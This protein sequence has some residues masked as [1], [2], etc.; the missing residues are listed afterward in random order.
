MKILLFVLTVFSA[1]Y[2]WSYTCKETDK[3]EDLRASL[4]P[5]RDQDSIGWC[6]TFTAAD[7]VTDY[8]RRN[9]DQIPKN[10][11]SKLDFTKTENTVS[12]LSGAFAMEAG[13]SG[14]I[15]FTAGADESLKNYDEVLEINNQIV[16]INEELKEQCGG[17]IC[18]WGCFR[19]SE[20]VECKEWL[21]K[22][23]TEKIKELD[24]KRERLNERKSMYSWAYQKGI[25]EGGRTEKI[26]EYFLSK[27]FSL[28][29]QIS[30]EDTKNVDFLSELNKKML[31]AYM[32]AQTKDEALCNGFKVIKQVC[33]SCEDLFTEIKPT[34]ES[35]FDWNKSV[36]HEFSNLDVIKNKLKN[37]DQPKVNL[38]EKKNN[39]EIREK[40]NHY[41]GK[42]QIVAI[43]YDVKDIVS[44]NSGGHASSLVGR[45]CVRGQEHFIL[46]NS[47]GNQACDDFKK[48]TTL[49]GINKLGRRIKYGDKTI[50]KADKDNFEKTSI[51]R[52]CFDQCQQIKE[53][54]VRYGNVSMYS[55]GDPI[56]LEEI[57]RTKLEKTECENSCYQK[58]KDQLSEVIETF[59][60]DKGYYFIRSEKLLNGLKD[61]TVIE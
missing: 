22:H 41:L 21:K 52:K 40:I 14:G 35:G 46:R 29:K 45:T 15:A 13:R 56:N 16:K 37:P 36:F 24:N 50:I 6:Y 8:L 26:A 55:M 9:R 31:V 57:T 19:D 10:F 43:G 7:L 39:D 1:S 3:L 34:L 33:S 25:I 58:S 59:E 2:A 12:P 61:I 54:E 23:D 27:G 48:S 28:E 49:A 51:Y 42:G 60:C 47:W 18:K 20:D 11:S 5:L 4:A 30:S 17:E 44:L 38:I 53:P 32:D